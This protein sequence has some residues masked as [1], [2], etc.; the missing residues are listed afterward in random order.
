MVF[1]FSYPNHKNIAK[2]FLL[3][4]VVEILYDARFKFSILIL[5]KQYSIKCVSIKT[6][7]LLCSWIWFYVFPIG[8]QLFMTFFGNVLLM[9]L[10]PLL[11]NEHQ[12]LDTYYTLLQDTYFKIYFSHDKIIWHSLIIIKAI[13]LFLFIKLKRLVFFSV[14]AKVCYY[15]VF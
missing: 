14:S 7:K 11:H 10:V 8:I 9:L 12:L 15:E 5:F 13:F 3:H 1:V 6:R 4:P 2:H